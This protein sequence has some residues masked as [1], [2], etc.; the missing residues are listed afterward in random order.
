MVSFPFQHPMWRAR[1]Y[2]SPSLKDKLAEEVTVMDGDVDEYCL[3]QVPA[4]T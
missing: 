1:E 3:N 4:G 2:S